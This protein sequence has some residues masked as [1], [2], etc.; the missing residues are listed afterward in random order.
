M[1]LPVH[2]S[3]LRS[4]NGAYREITTPQHRRMVAISPAM[5]YVRMFI[6]DILFRHDLPILVRLTWVSSI[7]PEG[8]L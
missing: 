3:S 1:E 2:I 7:D 6:D 5:N 8:P 4:L